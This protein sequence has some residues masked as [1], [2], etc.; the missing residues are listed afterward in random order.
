MVEW[1]SHFVYYMNKKFQM[2]LEGKDIPNHYMINQFGPDS[3]QVKYSGTSM[4]EKN[5]KTL[6][7]AL[8]FV[9]K[10][11]KLNPNIQIHLF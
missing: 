5:F 1:L 8:I 9:E 7:E 3:F 4:H 10:L 6:E 2:M 11:K